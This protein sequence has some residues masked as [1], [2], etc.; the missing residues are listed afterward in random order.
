[1]VIY[2]Y[3][4]IRN[5]ISKNIQKIYISIKNGDIPIYSSFRIVEVIFFQKK[6]LFDFLKAISRGSVTV[7]QRI[8]ICKNTSR[9]EQV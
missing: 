4:Y 5:H 8:I 9:N 7:L 2:I 1:M 6:F 3:I